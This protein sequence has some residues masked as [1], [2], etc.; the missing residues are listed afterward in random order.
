MPWRDEDP[1]D[2]LTAVDPEEG[3]EFRTNPS[4]YLTAADVAA[5][6]QRRINDSALSAN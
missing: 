1:F 3:Q 2:D 4:R 5:G 6:I